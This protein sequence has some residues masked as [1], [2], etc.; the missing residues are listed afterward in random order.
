M[1]AKS[2]VL[3]YIKSHFVTVKSDVLNVWQYL[4]LYS[5]GHAQVQS[6]LIVPPCLHDA[7]VIP[8]HVSIGTKSIGVYMHIK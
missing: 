4:P 6:E 1:M 7:S 5:G 8:G 3:T 2:D